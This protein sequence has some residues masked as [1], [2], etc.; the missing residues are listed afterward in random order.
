MTEKLKLKD[1]KQSLLRAC[2]ALRFSAIFLGLALIVQT[3]SIPT[4]LAQ[5]PAKH[6]VTG[7][8]TASSDNSPLPGA[9]IKVKGTSFGTVTDVDGNFSVDAA[10]NDVLVISSIGFVTEETAVTGKSSID[11][12]LIEDIAKLD[13]VVVI[14][15]GT[16]KRKDLTGSISSITGD[17]L[18]KTVPT[19]FD[20]AL[21]GK[22]AGVMV[23]QISGQPGGGVSVQIHGVSSISGSN[24]PLYVIDGV[25]IPTPSDPGGG[26][27]PLNTINP[28]EIESIDVLKDASA[29]AIYGSQATNGVIV[30]T[31]KRGREG[32]PR[33]TYD[34]NYGYQKIAKKLETVNLQ[35]FATLLNE[36]AKVWGFDSRAEFANPQYLGTGTDWQNELFRK[37]PMSNHTL[38]LSGG[39]ANT[40]YLLSG[41]YFDQEGISLGSDFK[42][43]SVRLNLDNKTTKWLKIGTSIQLSHVD[44]N[45]SATSSSVIETAL[46]LTPDVPVKNPDGTWGGVTNTNGWV[47]QVNNPVAIALLV[48]D[49]KGRNEVFGNLYLE[50]QFT[51]DLSLRNE[52]SGNFDFKTEDKFTPTYQFG[53]AVN[54]INSSEYSYNQYY[55]NAVRNFLTY[56]HAFE[57]FNINALA[58]HEAQLESY[59]N[60][61]A[62]RTNFPSNNVISV[63]AG[64]GTTA[65]N[66]GN[67]GTGPA[68]ESYFGRVN[69]I[70]NEKYLLTGNVRR[71][72]SSNFPAEN[73]W[74]T[75]YSGAIAWRINNEIF[76]KSLK[77]ISDL[78]LRI[79]YGLTN[80]QN[81]PGNTYVTQLASAAN[82][83]SGTAQ[84]QY[85]LGNPY[86]QWE[87][88]KY[89]NV[90]LDGAF[91]NSKINFSLDLYNRLTDG[92]LLKIPLPSYSGTTAE[93]SPG[94]LIAPYVNVGS[95][96]NKGF[97]FRIGSINIDTKKFS[98]KTDITVSRNVNKILSLGSG[99][100]DANL[101]QTGDNG[102]VVEK[103]VVGQAIGSFYGYVYDGIFATA[104]DFTTH[105]LPVDQNGNTRTISSAGGGIWYGDRKYKDLN[106]DGVIDSKDQK[107]LGSPLPEFQFGFNNTFSYKN[108]DL[109]I[110]FSGSVGNKVYNK[111]AIKQTNPQNNTSYFTS[112][113]DYAK[114]ALIDPN[115]SATDVNNVYVTNPNTKIVGL[116]NDNT[117]ENMRPSDLYIEDGTF[118][119]CKNITLGYRLPANLLKKV[120]VE[121]LRFYFTVTNAFIIKKY[122]GMDPEIGSWDSLKAGWDSGYYPQPRVY[123]FGLN[124]AL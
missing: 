27:N 119:R 94:A 61:S 6:K 38:T 96:R 102:Y 80:N 106:G 30:I 95:I 97:D 5:E 110:F 16:S 10:D 39:N 56:N 98:W 64:D 18:R 77:S 63:D 91:F 121:S 122:S 105:A 7:K 15:Y 116:R 112:V 33:V 120:H 12:K 99:G 62:K 58:G 73:R 17:E 87:K 13:E 84:A 42:R 34:F 69:F 44:E 3:T 108:F 53:K 26:S 28:A 82:G 50:I 46:N 25:I 104:S 41:S 88:T 60:V 93:Y 37:A 1:V 68:L 49:K 81:I 117:N 4:L 36:R 101:S 23:Q 86:V 57:K 111:L 8:I 70:W 2:Y 107:S 24:S 74:V 85:N 14:G 9:S 20:Q 79:G 59:A 40:Q 114:L 55:K 22:V 100:R 71:D 65:T 31:T 29:T 66:S 124:L 35:Q 123:T 21:Q 52:V 54:N 113:M 45:V 90:G 109:S 83:L 67:K 43:Y 48:K 51:K 72:G 89:S 76:L 78:K 47:D 11:I 115:G 103:S 92:L 32:T 19:T 118:V 75:T